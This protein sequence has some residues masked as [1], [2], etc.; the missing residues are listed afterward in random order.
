VIIL[1][2]S[3]QGLG[4]FGAKG[5]GEPAMT[6]TPAAVMNAVSR[7]AGA[8]LTQFPLTAERVLAA[9]TNPSRADPLLPAGNVKNPSPPSGERAG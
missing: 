9:M 1:L 4:P 5:I 6:P 3:G 2:E 7:A 8:P